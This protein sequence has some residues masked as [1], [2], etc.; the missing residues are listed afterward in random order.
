[1]VD[2]RVLCRRHLLGEHGE[3]HKHRHCFERG[4][5][6]EGRRGQIEPEAMKAR[7]DALADEMRR[8]GFRHQSPYAQPDLSGYDLEGF[9]ID[10]Q[11]SLRLLLDRCEACRMRMEE[12]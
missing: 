3:L 9:T 12:K 2:P 10:R 8:R 4:H 1:M 5:S 7:H 11:A 6:I